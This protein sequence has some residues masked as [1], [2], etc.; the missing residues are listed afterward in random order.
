MP[1]T[2][3]HQIAEMVPRKTS[4]EHG[5]V[6]IIKIGQTEFPKEQPSYY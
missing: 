1:D 6:L 3:N 2:E 5:L 4:N